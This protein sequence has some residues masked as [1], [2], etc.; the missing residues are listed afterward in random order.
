MLRFGE[1]EIKYFAIYFAA[2]FLINLIMCIAKYDR[3]VA[4]LKKQAAKDPAKQ[5]ELDE[6][7]TEADKALI[8]KHPLAEFTFF[9]ML[10]SA[11]S[12][13]LMKAG[14]LVMVRLN[15]R[16]PVF[17][18]YPVQLEQMFEMANQFAD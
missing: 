18:T 9:F 10:K 3:K 6:A 8:H 14:H 15:A 16:P 2:Q 11:F 13:L 12:R 5:G 4:Q 1:E 17:I 7:I